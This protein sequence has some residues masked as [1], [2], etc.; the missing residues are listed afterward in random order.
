MDTLSAI[1]VSFALDDYSQG[2]A[3]PDTLIRFPFSF[4]KLDKDL[5]WSAFK[6]EKANIVYRNTVKMIKELGMRIIAEGAETAEHIEMLH[7]LEVDFIQGFY[8][9]RPLD[10]SG[11]LDV[12]SGGNTGHLKKKVWN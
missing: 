4:I 8:Y 2:Y 12:I 11:F 5:L 10:K 9:G 6:S 1:G 7:E 3:N